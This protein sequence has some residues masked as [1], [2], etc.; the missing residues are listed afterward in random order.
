MQRRRSIHAALVA[1]ALVP[2]GALV[3]RALTHR[4]GANPI[5][6]VT[7]QTGLTALRLLLASLAITPLRRLGW[8]AL[9]PYRR[10]LGLLAFVY[11]CLHLATWVGLDLFFDFSAIAED[12]AKRPYITVGFA[13]FCCLV[14][15][16]LTSTRASIRRLGSRRWTALH[17]LVY[18]AAALGALHFYWLVKA[19]VREPLTYVAAL[20]LLLAARLPWRSALPALALGAARRGDPET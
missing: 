18:A 14:P 13:A 17:R 7:H 15:L 3:Y 10:T 19:D 5:E 4:L 9:A 11:A 8:S 1:V 16:A 6:E 20:A 2:A 12:V